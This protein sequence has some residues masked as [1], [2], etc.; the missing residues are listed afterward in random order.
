ME[1]QSRN[2]LHKLLLNP[3]HSDREGLTDLD[4]RADALRRSTIRDTKHDEELLILDILE[5]IKQLDASRITRLF[6][7][8]LQS[9]LDVH[10]IAE[11]CVKLMEEIPEKLTVYQKEALIRCV[12]RDARELVKPDHINIGLASLKKTDPWTFAELYAA[13]DTSN[14]VFDFVIYMLRSGQELN[15]AALIE[16]IMIWTESKD[17]HVLQRLKRELSPL[18]E[19]KHD[20]GDFLNHKLASAIET[21]RSSSTISQFQSQKNWSMYNHTSTSGD[22]LPKVKRSHMIPSYS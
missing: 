7:Y 15:S 20:I 16:L 1:T 5:D 2:A 13:V 17:L 3:G 8:A 9:G 21:N 10:R 18:L 4:K 22:V 14:D 11:R 12:L 19:D 6:E